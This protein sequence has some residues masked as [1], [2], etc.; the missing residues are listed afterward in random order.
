MGVWA[1]LARPTPAAVAAKKA[2][3]RRTVA[4]KAAARRAAAKKAAAARA[5]AA[6]RAASARGLP[7]APPAAAPPA[8]TQETT[9]SAGLAPFDPAPTAAVPA[10][11]PAPSPPAALPPSTAGSGWPAVFPPAAAAQAAPGGIPL[12][13]DQ[14]AHL[15][16]RSTFG[17]TAAMTDEVR[18]IGVGAWLDRQLAPESIDDGAVEAAVQ[19]RWPRLALSEAGAMARLSPFSWDLMFELQ[20]AT[21]LRMACSQRQLQ[22]VMVDVWSNHLNVTCPSD[23][24]WA[25]RHAYDLAIRLHALGSFRELLRASA[26]SPAMLHYLDNADSTGDAPNENYGRELLELHTVGVGAGYTEAEVRMSALA[27]TGFTVD[28][29]SQAFAYDARRHYVGPLRVL[30]WGSDNVSAAGGLA[31]GLDYLDHLAR[32]PATARRIATLLATRFVCDTPP[33][34]LVDRLAAAYTAHDTA[35]VPVLR[36]LFASPEFWSCLGQ[37]LRR[38]LD[39]TVATMRVLSYAPT[40]DG[41]TDAWEGLCWALGSAGQAP[42]AWEPPNGYPDV[43]AAWLSTAGTLSR[44]NLALALTQGWWSGGASRAADT[45]QALIGDPQPATA[46][47]LIDRLCLRLL[48]QTLPDPARSALLGFF[49]QA[50]GDVP[51]A[52]RL[53]YRVSPVVALILSSPVWSLR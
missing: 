5:A 21:L 38:P 39:A 3:A 37:K 41:R 8:P 52:W 4:R 6:R 33:G 2:A 19:A 53:Q 43:A 26:T 11:P 51:E 36:T 34:A 40:A 46:G 47:A 45:W 10:A 24:V 12:V 48:G 42:L 25:T 16:R 15:L 28:D 13:D 9:V 50:A 7:P 31:V 20:R 18:R 14:V 30:D 44:W 32:H 23:K 22:E 35:I 49:G 29:A 27:L 1:Q 17:V